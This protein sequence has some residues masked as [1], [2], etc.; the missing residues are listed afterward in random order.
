MN[1]E[2]YMNAQLEINMQ[3][4]LTEKIGDLVTDKDVNLEELPNHSTKVLNHLW[5]LMV[6]NPQLELTAIDDMAL[7]FR[8]VECGHEHYLPWVNVVDDVTQLIKDKEQVKCPHCPQTKKEAKK[9]SNPDNGKKKAQPLRK[10]DLENA[11]NLQFLFLEPVEKLPQA[12]QVIVKKLAGKI[13]TVVLPHYKASC[14][15]GNMT[16]VKN[17][18]VRLKNALNYLRKEQGVNC[19][20]KLTTPEG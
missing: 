3:E 20:V 7:Y 8:F 5:R 13:E 10:S 1:W 15:A 12:K 2:N 9:M 14:E 4:N 6:E 11:K 17:A 19:A 16:Q 18:G